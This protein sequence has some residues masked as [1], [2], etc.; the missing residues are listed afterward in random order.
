MKS[1]RLDDW[2]CAD[3]LDFVIEIDKAKEYK[4]ADGTLMSYYKAIKDC[5]HELDISTF[6]TQTKTL[7]CAMNLYRQ[8]RRKM[9]VPNER[10]KKPSLVPLETW[11]RL[12]QLVL[13]PLGRTREDRFW[14][15]VLGLVMVW[16]LN[17]GAR[18]QDVLNLK[19]NNATV[20]TLKGGTEC[21]KIN[22]VEGKSNRYGH[23][24]S[25]VIL[26]P[27]PGNF[28]LCPMACYK[29]L[30]YD[31]PEMKGT[32]C[33]P[34]Y[35]SRSNPVK[36]AQIMTRLNHRCDLLKMDKI[37]RPSAHSARVYFINH[38]LEDGVPIE[39][40]ARAV[41]WSSSAMITHYIR[42]TEFLET[43]PN[44]TVVSE[45]TS[46]TRMEKFIPVNEEP[47]QF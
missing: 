6:E 34:N 31:F 42:N 22:I 45:D 44:R 29:N 21:W 15:R 5:F 11:R 10:I 18:M 35:N 43:A 24:D 37:N 23:R 8:E 47:F 4:L 17:S 2:T 14:N 7:N 3:I 38:A 36:R 33:I 16:C 1:R 20:V 41:N 30:Y 28:I 46:R 40:I 32:Y 19:R 26:Y 39:Q 12:L 25:R 27:N 13:G 9:L